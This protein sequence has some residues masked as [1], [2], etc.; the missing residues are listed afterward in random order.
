M[1]ELMGQRQSGRPEDRGA[2]PWPPPVGPPRS[3]PSLRRWWPLL[4]IGLIAVVVVGVLAHPSRPL[5]TPTPSPTPAPTTSTQ[6]T[7]TRSTSTQAKTTAPQTPA[8]L[9]SPAPSRPTT[10]AAGHP[11]LGVTAGWQLFGWGS[12]NLVRIRPASGQVIRTAVPALDSSGPVTLLV[13]P[14]RALIRPG[15]RVTGYG[16]RDGEPATILAG[17]LSNGGSIVPGPDPD[18]LWA[19]TGSNGGPDVMTLVD[20]SGHATTTAFPVPTGWY[21]SYASS[22]GAGGLL[23]GTEDGKIAHLTQGRA[24]T[25]ADQPLLAVGPTGYLFQSCDTPT[26]CVITEQDRTTGRRHPVGRPAPARGHIATGLIAA[27][28]RTATWTETKDNN[29]QVR[30]YLLDLATGVQRTLRI[31]SAGRDGSFVYSPDSRWLFATADTGRLIAI[32]VST[33]TPHDL[34]VA[35]PALTLL[36]VRS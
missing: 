29:P 3:A 7:A 21:G 31:N 1:M 8:L 22:D 15:D 26:T 35:L 34:G 28:G 4:V 36:A 32:E 5:A 10:T 14:D 17:T 19:N 16:V 24:G 13:G 27:D 6:A 25:L 18:H 12:G 20:W 11:L 23:F 2:L 33:G 9:T 30:M